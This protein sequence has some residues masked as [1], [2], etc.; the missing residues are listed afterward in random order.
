MP[1]VE[2]KL[3]VNQDYKDIY[4]FRKNALRIPFTPSG[5][6][7]STSKG[8]LAVTAGVSRSLLYFIIG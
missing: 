6:V 5:L 1:Y 3:R 8:I 4:G 2:A 7:S